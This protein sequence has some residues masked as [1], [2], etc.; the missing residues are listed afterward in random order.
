MAVSSEL[1]NWRN[2]RKPGISTR[3]VGR[4]RKNGQLNMFYGYPAELIAE[5]WIPVG[6]QAAPDCTHQATPCTPCWRNVQ[7]SVA[8]TSNA[9]S[10]VVAAAV[11]QLEPDLM[12]RRAVTT[13]PYTHVRSCREPGGKR[14][15]RKPGHGAQTSCPG[16]GGSRSRSCEISTPLLPSGPGDGHDDR[17]CTC[18]SPAC[19]RNCGGRLGS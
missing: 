8:G 19:R 5:R 15:S 18:Q 11:T 9:V 12:T 4:P 16:A 10:R 3:P 17:R 2:F 7:P 13:G 14:R 6:T 1:A